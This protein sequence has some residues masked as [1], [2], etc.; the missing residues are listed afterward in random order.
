MKGRNLVIALTVGFFCLS[1]YCMADEAQGEKGANLHKNIRIYSDELI[2]PTLQC[3]PGTTVTWVNFSRRIQAEIRFLDKEVTSAAEC[4]T[5]FFI[6]MDDTF[7]S[8]KV[9]IGCTASLCFQK[10]GTYHYMIRETKT[11]H[12]GA[13]H[14]EVRG[15]IIVE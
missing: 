2:P 7:E 11:F 5:N 4:P 12:P 13:M 6:G 3:K 8:H 10:K 15:T 9:C 1:A 14:K